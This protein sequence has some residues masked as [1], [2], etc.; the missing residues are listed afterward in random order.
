MN[1]LG[2]PLVTRAAAKHFCEGGNIVHNSTVVASVNGPP[3]TVYAG[4]KGAV[5]AIAGVLIESWLRARS[6]ST[7]SAPVRW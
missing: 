3:S 5:N 1:G 6:G 7:L 4:A 2:D